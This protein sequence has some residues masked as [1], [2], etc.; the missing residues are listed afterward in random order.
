[1]FFVALVL[2][3]LRGTRPE[4]R[5]T[6]LI[7]SVG[8]L[9]ALLITLLW[10]TQLPLAYSLPQWEPSKLFAEPPA[11]LV[12]GLVFPYAIAITGLTLA[13]LLTTV[14]REDAPSSLAWAGTLLLGGLG[15][16]AVTA[17]NPLTLVLVWCA[18]DIAELITQLGS[19]NTPKASER[20]VISFGTRLAGTYLLLWANA[21]SVSKSTSFTFTSM[22]VETSVYLIV[23]SGLRLG[24]LPLHLPY[25]S[26]SSLRRGFGTM[27]R[28]ISAASSLVLLAH[29]PAMQESMTRNILLI[30]TIIASL[31]GGWMWLNASDELTGRPFWIIGM[32]SLAISSALAGNPLGA[33]AWGSALVLTGG[34]LFLISVQH[35]NINRSLLAATFAMSAL[36]FS[37]TASGWQGSLPVVIKILLL[38]AQGM[39]MAGF[40]KNTL[41]PG[42]KTSLES[43]PSWI[44]SIYPVGIFILLTIQIALGFLGWDGALQIGSIG[45]G[46]GASI[47][48]LGLIWLL[49]RIQTLS[50]TRTRPLQSAASTGIDSIYRFLWTLYL[51]LGKITQFIT[52]LLEG[53][54]GMIW[55]A[56]FITLFI[57]L[58]QQEAK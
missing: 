46:I 7:G 14:A 3:I 45:M 28:L 12:D 22:P 10:Q 40:I 4:F 11:F 29:I 56:L 33:V 42:T 24:V 48:A 50:L 21:V 19:A 58:L 15:L 13:V 37:L 47:L 20:I 5:F 31:F 36:P 44:R 30:M 52:N 53:E 17:N 41:R 25:S 38:V 26:D 16:M 34:M 55:V 39:L 57:S 51:Q 32:S 1:M 8:A 6:W 9:I 54:S 2:V 27:L 43:M 18:L 49:P 23:A 35:K